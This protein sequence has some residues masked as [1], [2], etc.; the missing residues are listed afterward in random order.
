VTIFVE[1]CT[2]SLCYV[3]TEDASMSR[4]VA[5]PSNL[6]DIIASDN[7]AGN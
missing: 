7:N 1:F 6:N 2:F 4:T 3:Y 5:L